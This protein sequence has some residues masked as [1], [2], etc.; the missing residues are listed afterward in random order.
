MILFKALLNDESQM[1]DGE[2]MTSKVPILPPR[3]LLK[4]NVSANWKRLNRRWD[5]YAIESH[6][7]A[8]A[9]AILTCLGADALDMFDGEEKADPVEVFNTFEAMHLPQTRHTMFPSAKR[10]RPDSDTPETLKSLKLHYPCEQ[11][12]TILFRRPGPV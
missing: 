7:N 10:I 1:A 9:M 6:L 11:E 2:G 12:R 5:K 3:Y 8:Q 4:E